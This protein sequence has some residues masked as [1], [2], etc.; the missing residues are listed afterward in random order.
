MLHR[1]PVARRLS[2]VLRL[3][4]MFVRRDLLVVEVHGTS[5]SPAL[6]PGDRLFCSRRS[7]ISVGAIV[8]RAAGG[9]TPGYHIKRLAA[10]PGSYVNGR[11]IPAGYCWIEGDN[12]ATSADS[13]QLGPIPVAELVAVA[14]GRLCREGLVDVTV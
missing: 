6:T 10:L 11:L 8:I 7:P 13:R 3:I 14:V 4:G 9:E 2:L 12:K 5:M 1:S